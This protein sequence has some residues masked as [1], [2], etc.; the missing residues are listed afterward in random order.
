MKHQIA[1]IHG[2][3]ALDAQ[4]EF[5]QRLRAK[6]V[7][8]DDFKLKHAWKETLQADLGADFEVFNPRM[9]N[10]QN[11]RYVEWE[12]WF[13]KLIPFLNDGIICIG[14]SLGGLFLLKY[15][16]EHIFPK[17]IEA[18]ILVAAP[19]EGQ[20][21]KHVRNSNFILGEDLSKFQGQTEHIIVLHSKDDPI[22]PYRDFEKYKQKLPSARF[23]SFETEGH[24][25][26]NSVPGL[27]EMIKNISK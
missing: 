27:V 5:L 15:L 19:Y 14:H 9:P 18:V 13:E 21:G 6:N 12:I 10:G 17:K 22:V 11:A 2:G 4:E 26:G 8:A 23:F 7:T 1:V 3:H 24:F 16:S 20:G 25:N